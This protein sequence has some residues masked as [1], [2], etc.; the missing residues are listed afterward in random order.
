MGLVSTPETGEAK[1]R[2]KWEAEHTP[3]GPP[4]RRYTYRDL[5]TWVHKAGRPEHGKGGKDEIIDSVVVESEK[6]ETA[7]WHDGYRR[8]PS[9]ALMVF[10]DQSLEIAKLAANVDWQT[11]H[12]LSEKAVAEVHQAQSE[13]AG[14]MPSVPVTP[15]KKR[16]K[17]VK[18]S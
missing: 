8:N 18:E 12:G 9:D 5:P 7:K 17:K 10:A 4:L 11:K 1:E 2:V 6:D 13:H 16:T 3:F 15:I 14:H